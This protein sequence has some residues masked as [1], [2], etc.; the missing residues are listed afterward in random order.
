MLPQ[1]PHHGLVVPFAGADEELDRLAGQARLD[2]DR[3]GGLSL[4]AAEPAADDQGGGGPLLV[5]VNRG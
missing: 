5:A 2:G 1:L 3:L 4:E